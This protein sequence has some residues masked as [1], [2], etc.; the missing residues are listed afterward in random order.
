[1]S[2]EV[3][4]FPTT[5]LKKWP[6][7]GFVPY[8]HRHKNLMQEIK[9]AAFF[10]LR[11]EVENNPDLLQVIPYAYF[12]GWSPSLFV[13][14][15][16]KHGTEDRLHSKWSIGVGGHTNPCDNRGGDTFKNAAIREICEE[17]IFEGDSKRAP[18]PVDLH[19]RGYI[20][21]TSTPVDRVHFG[22]VY[23]V[24]APSAKIEARTNDCTVIGWKS[25]QHLQDPVTF[26]RLENWSQD[27]VTF[28]SK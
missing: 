25:I 13:Y 24:G 20:R 27:L 11:H 18:I 7:E 12:Y 8:T 15:R 5:V 26:Q 14:E 23:S 16:T 2:E 6:D 28:L 4:V 17:F 22:V 1:M 9:E 10:A 3:W 21:R 19:L